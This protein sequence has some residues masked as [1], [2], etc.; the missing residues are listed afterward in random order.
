[1]SEKWT[2]IIQ[3]RLYQMPCCG[4]S[5][6]W[7]NPRKPNYCPECGQFIIR[8]MK[9]HLPTIDEPAILKNLPVKEN[10]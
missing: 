9:E 1:M 8:L 5:L 4:H 2:Q 7:V 10:T 3:F 6:C